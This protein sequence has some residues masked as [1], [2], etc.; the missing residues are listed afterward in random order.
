MWRKLLKL[1]EVAYD[2]FRMEVKDGKSTHFWFDDWLGKGR[3]IDIT[4]AVGTTYL[5]LPRRATVSEA[6]NQT[7]WAIRGQRSRHHHDLYAEVVAQPLPDPHLGRD[8]VLWKHGEDDYR[9]SFSSAKT[10]DQI[11]LRKETVWSKV[12]WFAQGIPRFSFI[13]WLAVKNRLS[14][15]DRM[16]SWGMIQCCT[17]C[18][19]INETRDHLFFA[20]PYSFTVWHSMANRIPEAHTD[21]DWQ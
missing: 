18:G 12:V 14:T 11:R 9:D 4:G 6:M 19:E 21:P 5:G 1:R 3:L 17:L 20:C 8:V 10:W 13:T 15:G 16:R 2:F 7:G